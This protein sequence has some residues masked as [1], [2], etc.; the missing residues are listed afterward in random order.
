MSLLLLLLTACTD[1]G[2]KESS[3]VD[4]DGDGVPANLDCN[5]ADPAVYP[6]AEERCDGV[7]N[8]C[9]EQVDDDSSVDG[10]LYYTDADEDGYGDDAT[11]N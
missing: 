2:P 11:E 7:D 4:Q 8:N 1:G 9:D 5:D 3:T 10:I 6:D